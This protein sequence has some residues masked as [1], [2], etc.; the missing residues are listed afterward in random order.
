MQACPPLLGGTARSV[1]PAEPL[2]STVVDLESVL[3][4]GG[5]LIKFISIPLTLLG[6]RSQGT[7]IILGSSFSMSPASHL[8]S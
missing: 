1:Q 5:A 3:G 6:G 8:L 7:P 4:V 2:G